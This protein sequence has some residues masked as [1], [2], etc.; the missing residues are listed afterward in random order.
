MR[1]PK[2]ENIVNLEDTDWKTLLFPRDFVA[3]PTCIAVKTITMNTVEDAS[4]VKLS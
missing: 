1:G 4:Q 2:I 3:S